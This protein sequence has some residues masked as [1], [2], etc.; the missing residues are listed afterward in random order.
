MIRAWLTLLAAELRT[1]VRDTAG[2]VIPIALPMLILV[3][4]AFNVPGDVLG[5]YVLPLVLVIVIATV[6]L[7]NTPSFLATYRRTGVLQRLAVTPLHPAAVLGAQ[8]VAGLTQIAAGVLLAVLVAAAGFGAALPA[9]PATTVAVL[10]LAALAMFGLGLVIA[11]V[12]PTANAALA[13]GLV[14]F[15]ALS[16]IGGGFG[17]TANMPDGLRRAGEALPFG[18]AVQAAGAAWSGAGPEAGHVVSLTVCAAVS[19]LAA[20]KLFRWT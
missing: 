12:A 16:A 3:V 1:V 20:V 17:P 6:G 10:L 15:F 13:A 8:L 4:N 9:A 11:A 5:R 18:A 19:G 14:V 2:L 7:V